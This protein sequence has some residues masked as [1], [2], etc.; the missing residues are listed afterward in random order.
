M[1]RLG[2]RGVEAAV[3]GVPDLAAGPVALLLRDRLLEASDVLVGG[4]ERGAARDRHLERQ[5]RV[6]QLLHRDRLR[7]QHQR[8]RLRE[9][10][11]HALARRPRDED[12]AGAAAAD[13]DQVGGRQQPQR[14]AHSRAADA[15]LVGELLLGADPLARLEL[16]LLQPDADLRRDLLARPG[17]G[18]QDLPTG[19]CPCR[20]H[21]GSLRDPKSPNVLQYRSVVASGHTVRTATFDVLRRLELT[22]IFS[23]PGSTEIAF[24]VGLPDDLG[25]MLALHEGSVVAWPRVRARAWRARARAAALDARDSAT[26]S[27]QSRRRASNRAPLVVHGRPAGPAASRARS[28]SS[29]G[30]WTAW[31]AST[32]CGPTS[33]CAAQDVRGGI[34]RAYHDAAT[35][36]GPALV[37]VP[38]DDWLAPAPEAHEVLGPERLLRATGVAG[39]HRRAGRPGRGAPV[40][41]ARRRSRHRQPGGL[42][43][44]RGAGRAAGVPRVAGGLRRSGGLPAGPPAVSPGTFRPDARGCARRSRSTTRAR[45]RHRRAPQYPYDARPAGQ[46]RDDRVLVTEDPVEAHRS[47]AALAVLGEPGAVC[48]ALVEAVDARGGARRTPTPAPRR[49]P[50]PAAGEPLRAGHVFAALAERLPLTRSC[51][52]E[53][54]SSRPD[55]APTCPPARRWASSARWAG[56][57]SGCPG[58][59]GCGWRGPS[60]RCSR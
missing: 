20:R 56:S 39:G 27:P 3:G 32:P 9:V 19:P 42:G 33:P 50:P 46:A 60:A 15:E 34:R 52:E 4:V 22:T 53:T 47:P 41:R 28:R 35:G 38:M 13:A 2:E 6:E 16:L 36:R 26:P 23:N 7:R 58:R 31:R 45:R 5:P 55:C 10:A 37:I 25:F 18:V 12:A 43:G 49:Y 17:G 24:L 51:V 29:R 57:G 54:P 1:R 59:S 21:W 8:D 44:A 11:A 48:G 30:G 14:L 40:A